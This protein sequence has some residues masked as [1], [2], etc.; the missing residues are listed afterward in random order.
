MADLKLLIERVIEKE[1]SAVQQQISAAE[2]KAQTKLETAKQNA[3]VEK[4]NRKKQIDERLKREHEI[5]KNTLQV[6][7]RNEILAVKQRILSDVYADAYDVLKTMDAKTTQ[8]FLSNVLHQFEQQGQLEVV[9]GEE[10][11]SK[12][13]S[14][15]VDNLAVEGTQVTLSAE[16]I[17]EKAG[18]IIRKEGIEYNY[19]FDALIE[20]VKNDVVQ[21][22]SQQLFQ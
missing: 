20:D 21:P 5:S 15:W 4:E 8:T 11:A 9:L 6:K 12:V 19:L 14:S 7:K 22:V 1:K 18:A 3:E 13:D 10:T 17:K 16:T 2:E